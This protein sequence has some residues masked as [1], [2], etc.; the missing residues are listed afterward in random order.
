MTGV[1]TFDTG[2][3]RY[4]AP[5][6]ADTDF[7]APVAYAV[8]GN[9][10][11]PTPSMSL[12]QHVDAAL[13]T[14]DLQSEI[15]TSMRAFGFAGLESALA[16]NL[17]YLPRD[18]TIVL[19]QFGPQW[20]LLA[21]RLTAFCAFSNKMILP[22]PSKS[23]SSSK[24]P[25]QTWCAHRT[26]LPE[27]LENPC[28]GAAMHCARMSLPEIQAAVGALDGSTISPRAEVKACFRRYAPLTSWSLILSQKNPWN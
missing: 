26:F 13:G 20:L 15:L 7:P 16:S 19:S 14:F 6:V 12:R 17:K 3:Q 25:E 23:S 8:D 21:E 4:Q 18:F 11:Q 24:E 9:P 28:G 22:C 2:S 10:I 1:V 27:T 5:A